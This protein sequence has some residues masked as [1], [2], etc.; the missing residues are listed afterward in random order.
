MPSFKEHHFSFGFDG[1][2]IE[3]TLS[4]SQKDYSIQVHSPTEIRLPG[5][6]IM[7]MIPVVYALEE[8]LNSTQYRR[9]D[10]LK[11]CQEDIKQYFSKPENYQTLD[12]K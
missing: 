8:D 1:Y 6:H 9:V 2:M 11:C 5:R 12:A 7:Y 4:Y 3:A 10:V